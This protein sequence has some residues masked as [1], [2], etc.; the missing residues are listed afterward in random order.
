M[1][2]IEARRPI[3]PLVAIIVVGVVALLFVALVLPQVLPSKSSNQ[4]VEY[5]KFQSQEISESTISLDLSSFNGYITVKPSDSR[6]VLINVTMKGT[7]DELKDITFDFKEQTENGTK[8]VTLK[9][10][11]TGLLPILGTS[12]SLDVLV[13]KDRVYYA[14]LDTSN[15]KIEVSSLKGEKL[16]LHTSN[17]MIQFTNVEFGIIEATTS[18]GE[19]KGSL[20]AN[21]ATLTT[22]NGAIR[23]SISNFGSYKIT[24]SNGR[25]EVNIIYNTPIK[26][27]ANTSNGKINY[28][29]P[30]TVT[31]S[32]NNN[33]SGYT[34]N[35]DSSKPN[36]DLQLSTSNGNI[37]MM[38]L[39]KD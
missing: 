27:Q 20:S 11:S 5:K 4:I 7:Q 38:Y 24:T 23:T 6:I 10:K 17:G 39:G 29:M 34:Y 25:I 3:I 12:A 13:P 36:I 19:I 35:Y 14:T 21:K 33:L 32:S 1:G 22:S 2:Q 18:N 26:I 37:D 31:Q 8:T 9:V 16:T 28:D 30:L 15:G